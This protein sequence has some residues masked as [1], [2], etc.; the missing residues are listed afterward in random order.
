M[1]HRPPSWFRGWPPRKRREKEGEKEEWK[2]R[3][4]REE[5]KEREV[6]NDGNVR[7]SKR[8]DYFAR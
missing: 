5:Q 2:G 4:G 6:V 7:F 3:E 8:S 1:L